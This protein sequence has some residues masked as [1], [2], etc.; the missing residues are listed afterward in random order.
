M[1]ELLQFSYINN[2]QQ[3]SVQCA[4]RVTVQ[5]T[6]QTVDVRCTTHDK[7]WELAKGIRSR[8]LRFRHRFHCLDLF[9]E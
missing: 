2:R 9:P 4:R 7:H 8:V 1:C 3:R 6:S 5:V